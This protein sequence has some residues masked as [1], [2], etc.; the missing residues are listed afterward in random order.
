MVLLLVTAVGDSDK[1]QS[2]ELQFP[3]RACNS[4]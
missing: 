2:G 4:L 1:G 3:Y